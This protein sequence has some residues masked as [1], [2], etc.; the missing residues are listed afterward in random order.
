MRTIEEVL[1]EVQ[2]IIITTHMVETRLQ[3][4]KASGYQIEFN[5]VKNS[6]IGTVYYMKRQKVFRI[7]IAASE[8]CG[9]YDK[10]FCIVLP[11]SDILPQLT[12]TIKIRNLPT[13]RK[14]KKNCRRL[15]C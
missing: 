13:H 3:L 6:G 12:E 2:E 9:N 4:L 10:A 7:Q 14:T 1:K 8:R 11:I 5:W 15:V